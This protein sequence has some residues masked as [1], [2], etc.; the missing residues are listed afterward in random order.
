MTALTIAVMLTTDA[1]EQVFHL[2]AS[3]SGSAG[4]EFV[5]LFRPQ[6]ISSAPLVSE[7]DGLRHRRDRRIRIMRA[8][9]FEL[10]ATTA[11]KTGFH[12][13][14]GPTTL[15]FPWNSF[16]SSIREDV[17]EQQRAYAVM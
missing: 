3:D 17:S 1:P 9:N 12:C 11:T 7:R 5:Q 6:T 4:G 16:V 2:C 8:L 15:T 10:R 14:R 13:R